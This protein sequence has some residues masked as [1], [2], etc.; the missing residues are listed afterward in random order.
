MRTRAEEGSTDKTQQS[1]EILEKNIYFK[2]FQSLLR[3]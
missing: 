2:S 1:K 3:I